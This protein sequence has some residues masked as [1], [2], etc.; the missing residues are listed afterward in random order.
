M[1]HSAMPDLAVWPI[2]LSG[3]TRG[4][5][6]RVQPGRARRARRA[7]GAGGFRRGAGVGRDA[8]AGGERVLGGPGRERDPVGGATDRS[9]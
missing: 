7:P 2:A 1:G 6:V 4:G 3:R 9:T 8:G 5:R